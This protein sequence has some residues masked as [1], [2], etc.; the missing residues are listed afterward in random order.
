MSLMDTKSLAKE[1]HMTGL[2]LLRKII[3]GENKQ[4]I[5]PAADWGDDEYEDCR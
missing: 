4:M 5:T 3:E 2:T 1:P